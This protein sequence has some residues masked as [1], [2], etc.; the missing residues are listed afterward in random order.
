MTVIVSSSEPTFNSAFT[1]AVNPVVK[2]IPSRLTVPKPGSVNVTAYEPG[3]RSTM[4]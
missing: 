2:A 1:V 3:R 4:R